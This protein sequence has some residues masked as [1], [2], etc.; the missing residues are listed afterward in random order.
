MRK[1]LLPLLGL[2]CLYTSMAGVDTVIAQDAPENAEL[3]GSW[4]GYSGLYGDVWAEGDYAYVGSFTLLDGNP[5]TVHIV[6]ISNPAA[7]SLAATYSLT[8]INTFRSPQDVKVADG[9]LFI[10]MESGGDDL[11][12]IVDVRDP[13][14]PVYLTSLQ[15]PGW[16][17]CHNTFYD[18]GFLYVVDS[19][20]PRCLVY[21]LRTF[22]PDNPPASP[23]STPLWEINDIGNVFVHDITVA[24]GRLYCAGWDSGLFIYDVSDVANTFPTFLGTVDGNNTHSMWPTD[25]GNYVVT[26]EERGGGGIK[27]YR[28]TD[29][30]GSVDLELTDSLVLSN[31]AFSVHNQLIVGNRLYVSWYQAGLQ[32]F[33]INP[34]SGALEFVASYD[35][36]AFGGGDSGFQ[37]AWG[38]YPFLGE[39]EVL[40]SDL[41]EGLF[42]VNVLG[43]LVS[44]DFPDGLVDLV[45]PNGGTQV[46][47]EITGDAGTPDP[48]SGLLHSRVDGGLFL[49]SPLT[50]DGS[51]YI[52][53]LPSAPC[54]STVDYYVSIETFE[55]DTIANPSDAPNE[56]YSALA[57]V[58]II[59][60]SNL[61]FEIDPG[62][63]VT[64]DASDGQ[65]ERGIPSGG[66][67]RGNPPTD[68]DGSGNCYLTDN[69]PNDCNS[70]VDGGTTTLTT[71]SFDMSG[72]AVPYVGYARW[73]DNAAGSNP[74]QDLFEVEVSNNG[75][76]DWF[77]LET[78]G[79]SGPESQGG[80]IDARV[81]LDGIIPATSDMVFRFSVS[82][83]IDGSVVEA[84]VDAFRIL[85]LECSAEDAPASVA[86]P[87]QS[88]SSCEGDSA[89]FTVS[90]AGAQP[91]EY[92]W[93]FNGD[94]I[95]GGTQATLPL[96]NVTVADEGSYTCFVSNP[97]GS[98]VSAPATLT[99]VTLASCD[100]ANACTFD[101]CSAAVCQN[102][103]DTPAG[104]CCNP[105]NGVLT[106]IDDGNACTDDACNGDGSVDHTPNFDQGVDCCN[107]KSGLLT[108]IDDSNA[109]TDDSCNGDGTVS[110]E[111]NFAVGVVCCNPADGSTTTIDDGNDCSSDICNPDTG[112]VD[113]TVLV[114]SMAASGG[115]YVAATPQAV[116]DDDVA[117]L[118]TSPDYPCISAYV[119]A[120]GSLTDTP[121][122]QPPSTW[123]T[124]QVFDELIVPG[125]A[126]SIQAELPG[127]DLSAGSVATTFAW[128]DVDN[129]TVVNFADVQLTVFAFQ[130][131]FENVTLEAADLEP[132][133]PNG[134]ANFADVLRGVNAFQGLTYPE[135]GCLIP[136]E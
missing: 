31:D 116:C 103:D 99:V 114:P 77:P 61:N 113:H 37:G 4:N 87:P 94:D 9:L 30:G 122:F 28:M 67:D 85:D 123:L 68:F 38:V 5:G 88:Q 56:F 55:G 96:K 63:A 22:D 20:N 13:S 130:A 65:W 120:D 118:L 43:P 134:V 135:T 58:G 66:C 51:A 29:N 131:D 59:E 78:V 36:S 74:G 91:I 7:P 12:E 108:P 10:G 101:S 107:P 1:R 109:C 2:V 76:V 21:D 16:N 84:G 104:E 32:V 53:T 119:D 133:Q 93:R 24:G 86:Q 18:G 52:G 40:V 100:D 80:W 54:G 128:G 3:V 39:E 98:D 48:A 14:S 47:V 62:W 41:E 44:F 132:C 6:D 92:Q 110:H 57:A 89:S 49:T 102:T 111:E 97:F 129:N 69:D 35:T 45:N 79:P 60:I 124:V 64:G 73:F 19:N 26:G 71:G 72:L 125:A 115:R 34:I 126:Y 95:V 8:A 15:A 33:D 83:L 17:T 23:I 27:V 11:V 117:L 42:I 25:D 136:C 82:D 121:L 127:G 90:A 112:E 81:A 75:G 105:A 46:R 106:S 70:D 50:F